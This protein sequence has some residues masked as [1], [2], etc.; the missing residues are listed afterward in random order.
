MSHNFFVSVWLAKAA[1]DNAN[2]YKLG[3]VAQL[4]DIKNPEGFYNCTIVSKVTV[5]FSAQA[6]W[7]I[8][9]NNSYC[10]GK[11]AYCA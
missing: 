8:F 7:P 10:L 4:L 6:I 2:S 9:Q 1:G 5:V 11:P 3:Y